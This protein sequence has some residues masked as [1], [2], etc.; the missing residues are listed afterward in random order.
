M[1]YTAQDQ[2]NARIRMSSDDVVRYLQGEIGRL[3]CTATINFVNVESDGT[4]SVV[5]HPVMNGLLSD[6]RTRLAD[7]IR[8]HYPELIINQDNTNS[9]SAAPAKFWTKYDK[10]NPPPNGHYLVWQ[11]DGDM[12][13]AVFYHGAWE[14]LFGTQINVSHYAKV[15][16][17]DGI[18]QS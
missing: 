5:Y 3:S 17:P 11:P 4:A 1:K 12:M 2:D 9:N 18:Y 10:G 7:Y 16:T 13:K 15:V 6:F 8:D 14:N